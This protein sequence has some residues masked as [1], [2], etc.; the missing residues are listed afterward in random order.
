MDGMVDWRIS[1]LSFPSSRRYQQF[2][3]ISI[4][5][6]ACT[7]MAIRTPNNL[8]KIRLYQTYTQDRINNIR[9]LHNLSISHPSASL[10]IPKSQYQLCLMPFPLITIF[11]KIRPSLLHYINVS[12]NSNNHLPSIFHL[13]LRQD[14]R[15]D[16]AYL[17]KSDRNHLEVHKKWQLRLDR[18]IIIVML[19]D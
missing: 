17:Q 6:R 5:H 19:I 3:D 7:Y 15:K 2:L 16:M 12:T 13:W 14:T 9:N 10:Q 8:Q 1:W 11:L 18:D 4:F